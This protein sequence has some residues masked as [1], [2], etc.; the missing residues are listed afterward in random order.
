METITIPSPTAFLNSP[1]LAT[2]TVQRGKPKSLKAKRSPSSV[3]RKRPAATSAEGTTKPKQSKS[4][5]GIYERYC[6]SSVLIWTALT[7]LLGCVTCKAKRLKCDETKPSC[8][9]CYKRQVECGGYK[10]DFKWR[11]F[12][13]ATFV[14]KPTSPTLKKGTWFTIVL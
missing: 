2:P 7:L 12:E 14:S 11:A 13:E 3:L 4:R 5:N 9:Q 1:V 10:K 6:H 8:Q